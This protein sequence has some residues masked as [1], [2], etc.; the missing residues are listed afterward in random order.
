MRGCA[1]GEEVNRSLTACAVVALLFAIATRAA[2]V[3]D[4]VPE[5]ARPLYAPH[6]DRDAGF[7]TPWSS[8]PKSV[9]GFLRWQLF[10]RNPYDKDRAPVIPVTANDGRGLAGFEPGATFTWVG[11]ATFA[12]HDGHD[13]ILTDPHFGPRALIPARL[14]PPG[15]PL[16]A[17]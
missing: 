7:F 1:G 17:V 3:P 13:V 11:H 6:G 12:I 2:D 16:E 4:G 5:S 14:V 9:W 8:D 10:S 15:I